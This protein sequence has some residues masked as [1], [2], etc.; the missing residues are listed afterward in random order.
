MSNRGRVVLVAVVALLFILFFSARGIAGFYIDYLWFDSLGL[1]SVFG[2]ILAAKL[3]LAAVFTLLFAAVLAVNLTIADRF[4]P[5]DTPAGP[6]AEFIDRYQ[7]FMGR[8]TWLVRIG[9]SLMFGLVAGLP[10]AGQWNSWLL[11]RNAS[12]FG[13]QDPL[14][15][16]DIGF[17]VFRLPFL[18]FVVDWLF[19]AIVIVL[20]VTVVAH[21]LNGGIR[22]QVQGRRVTPHV[23]LHISMLLAVLALL[24][25]AAYYLQQFELT[26]STRGY[27]DGAA[28][29]DVQAQLPAIRLL[30]AISV[31]AALLLV[32]NVWQ[33]GWRLPIIAVG[34]WGVVAV[35]AGTIYPAFVQRFVVQPAQSNLERPYIQRN[36]DATRRAMNLD[37]VEVTPYSVGTLTAQ[38]VAENVDT[39]R[40]VRLLDPLVTGESFQRIQAFRGFYKFNELDVDRYPITN[41]NGEEEVQQVLLAARELNSNDLPDS[42]WENRHLAY[43]HGWGLGMAQASKVQANGQP[44][45][46]DLTQEDAPGPTITRPEVYFG[47]TLT[48][49]AV[50]ATQRGEVSLGGSGDVNVSYEGS[51]GVRLSSGIRRAAYALQFGEW[52]IL[53]SNLITSDSRIL[54]IRDIKERVSHIAPFLQFDADPYPVVHQGRIVW[55]VDGYTTSDRYPY[56]QRANTDQLAPGS[57]LSGTRFNYARNSVKAVV[58][59]YEGSVT[60]YVVDPQDPIIQSYAKAFPALFTPLDEAPEG[61]ANH[62]RYPEDLFRVQTNVWSRYHISDARQFYLQENAWNVAQN[63]PKRQSD[64]NTTTQPTLVPGE[65]RRER[66]L[67]VPPYYTIM[68]QPGTDR[69]E[70]V[71][72]RSFVPFSEQDTR[73]ELMA[74]M[75]ASSEPDSYGKLRVYQVQ[76]TQVPGPAIAASD[77]QQTFAAELT[78]LD[79]QGSTV[80][81]GDLQLLPIGDSLM[82]VRPWFVQ[83]TTQ[84]PVPEMRFVTLSYNKESYRGATLEEAL[85]RAVPGFDDDLGTVIGGTRPSVPALPSQPGQQPGGEEPGGEDPGQQP[86]QEP[87]PPGGG[88]SV[89]ELLAE[90]ERL[91]GEAQVALRAG[92]LGEY[93]EKLEAAYAKLAEA[94]EEAIGSPVTPTTTAPPPATTSPPVTA[95]A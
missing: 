95:E 43:T 16:R 3:F 66:E 64:R 37:Q 71:I 72:L 38:D 76:G 27:V 93:Q 5:T 36:I 55:I 12:S 33:R 45:F 7:R 42:S 49:Y 20:I 25:A 47:E 13:V 15:G 53:V 41:S 83:A 2:G 73:K 82:Y 51:G 81:F 77:I 23:K 29:T 70:F 14:F 88:Q 79:Q 86:G 69:P 75:T 34:L 44:A 31:L 1:T 28:Y 57:D 54:Y 17:Y 60:F 87:G 22:L 10:A 18:S 62:F 32:V 39:L 4:A 9:V 80:T 46:I 48:S 63:P 78:L 61:L 8:R 84:T 50:V 92:R 11:F 90:A 35:V 68:R 91:Y 85:S 74:F 67:R 94:A 40:N 6:E 26:A 19:A 89:E 52:N 30:A 59:A 58:D 65:I 24:R 21:Y 56:A